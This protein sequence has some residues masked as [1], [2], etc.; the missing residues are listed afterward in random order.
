LL[1]EEVNKESMQLAAKVG[2]LT[3]E[4][5]KKALGKQSLKE[6]AA[7]NAGLSSIEL[8]D[9]ICGSLTGK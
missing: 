3:Y 1:H 2:K 7:Q 9:P 5:I 4:E 6:L 8:T